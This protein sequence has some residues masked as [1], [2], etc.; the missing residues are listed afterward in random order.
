MIKTGHY[1]ATQIAD[2]KKQLLMLAIYMMVGGAVWLDD[3]LCARYN[4]R[5]CTGHA[6]R[7]LR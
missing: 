5:Y 6:G 3:K 4:P 2:W 7:A 1:R